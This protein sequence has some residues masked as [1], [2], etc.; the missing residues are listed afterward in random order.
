MRYDDWDVI[1]FP[2][3]RDAKI[4]FKE[5]KVACH[6]VPDLELAHIHGPVGIPVM[7]CFVPSLPPGAGFQISLHC[8]RRP[9]LSQ[10]T[11]T[12]S[13][14]TDLIKFET[15]VLI[16][17]R[18][19]ASTILDRD[20]NGPHLI[21]TTCEFTKTGELDRL[22][23]PHFRRELLFQNHW[24]PGDEIG[25]IK[26][27]I[28]EGFPRDSLSA[29]IERVKNIVAFSFQHAPLEILENNGIAWPNQSMWQCSPFNSVMPVP[30]YHLEEGPS[31]HTHSPGKK[32]Q[33]LRN[34]KNQSFPA[35][36]MTNMAFQPQVDSDLLGNAASQIGYFDSSS[37]G[38]GSATPCSD[39]F[40]DAAYLDWANSLTNDQLSDSWDGQTMYPASARSQRQNTSDTIMPDYI[41]PHPSDPMHVSGPSLD[42]EP[43]TL[44]VPT[45]TPTRA[46][47][48]ESQ[49]KYPSVPEPK[50]LPPHFT[51]SLARSLL[52]QPFPLPVHHHH[53]GGPAAEV[54]PTNHN[55]HAISTQS[56]N[57]LHATGHTNTTVAHKASQPKFSDGAG[58]VPGPVLASSEPACGEFGSMI[59][60]LGCNN[61]DSSLATP[62]SSGQEGLNAGSGRNGGGKGGGSGCGNTATKRPRNFTPASVRAID[63]EDEPRRMS[64]Y[65]RDAGFG[66]TDLLGDVG[67]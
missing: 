35:P 36:I 43:M 50:G 53:T 8:W 49:D 60:S 64:P 1:L 34:I 48:E 18:L 45:N 31:S 47:A 28:T 33:P 66:V 16:D 3:G 37:F 41:P 17:G 19:V 5:F 2:T 38:S 6:V 59:A 21:T 57:F 13:K 67:A 27:I 12:Y 51:S 24:R 22:R 40:M 56:N 54:K 11:R 58:E 52:N 10:F 32:S 42:D 62:T 15:R 55:Q 63:Q 23:F 30:T 61:S 29:P 9:E 14:H 39:P 25:R 44:K 4:P 7:T 20:V 65:V 26:I 46:I